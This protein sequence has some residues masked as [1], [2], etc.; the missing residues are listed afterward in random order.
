MKR[1]FILTALLLL[2][3]TPS[4]AASEVYSG[5]SVNGVSE[6]TGDEVFGILTD[7]G[8]VRVGAGR[9][10]AT[11]Y[12]HVIYEVDRGPFFAGV[13]IGAADKHRALDNYLQ[14]TLTAGVKYKV[15]E[16]HSFVFRWMHMGNGANFLQHGDNSAKLAN[17][18]IDFFT[19]GVSF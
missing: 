3:S 13:G 4:F 19:V 10:T 9:F 6:F 7:I 17:K 11:H 18:G 15:N 16:D 1:L 2:L 5:H 14:F 12:A 8:P